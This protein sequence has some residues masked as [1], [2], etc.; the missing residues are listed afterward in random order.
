MTYDMIHFYKNI[1]IS[2]HFILWHDSTIYIPIYYAPLIP[3]FIDN[4]NDIRTI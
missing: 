3:F 4:R 2:T 1:I